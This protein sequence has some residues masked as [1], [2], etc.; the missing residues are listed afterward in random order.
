MTIEEAINGSTAETVTEQP[1]PPR[2]KRG[3]Y[4]TKK[5]Q[6][7]AKR[8]TPEQIGEAAFMFLSNRKNKFMPAPWWQFWKW[9]SQV[10]FAGQVVQEAMRQLQPLALRAAAK[11]GDQ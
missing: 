8:Q 4:N 5:K 1:A 11:D 6:E 2:K 7:A 3:P 9:R 10:E